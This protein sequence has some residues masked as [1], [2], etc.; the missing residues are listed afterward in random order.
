MKKKITR[1]IWENFSLEWSQKYFSNIYMNNIFMIITNFG[2]M[3]VL[4]ADSVKIVL[5]YF[6]T[7][8]I[9]E[10]QNREFIGVEIY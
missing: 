2:R 10:L 3:N 7:S 1:M 5:C 6:Y 8:Q 9:T 4:Y